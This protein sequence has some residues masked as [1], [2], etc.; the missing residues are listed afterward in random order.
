MRAAK[1]LRAQ[2]EETRHEELEPVTLSSVP[3]EVEDPLPLAASC[4]SES[5]TLRP[6]QGDAD[7]EVPPAEEIDLEEDPDGEGETEEEY[8]DPQELFDDW[9]LSLTR[10]QRRMLC[11]KAFV[12]GNA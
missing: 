5:S 11:M 7:E 2:Q 6:V 10:D 12:T 1:R 3:S 9:M 8:S 4:S